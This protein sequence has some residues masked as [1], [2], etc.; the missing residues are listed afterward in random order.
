MRVFAICQDELVIR[1]LDE[2]LLPSF[3]V[4][5]LVEIP[6]VRLNR[7]VA[8]LADDPRWDLDSPPAGDWFDRAL[9]L[10][11]V[12]TIDK[13]EHTLTRAARADFFGNRID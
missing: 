12:T 13:P 10:S 11:G 8:A 9:G 1:S 2:V 3:E 4:Q 6:K 7:P 5:F